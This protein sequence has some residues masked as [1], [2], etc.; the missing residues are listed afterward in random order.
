MP[1]AGRPAQ[2]SGDAGDLGVDLG[3]RG[4]TVV[5][6]P[7]SPIRREHDCRWQAE[8]AK[9]THQRRLSGGVQLDDTE[10]AVMAAADRVEGGLLAVVA[11]AA[12]LAGEEEHGGVA[13]AQLRRAHTGDA[14]PASG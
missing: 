5:D 13:L 8:D 1:S 6:S 7:Y 2:R 3:G 9:A 4:E 11:D 14:T 12:V 10:I